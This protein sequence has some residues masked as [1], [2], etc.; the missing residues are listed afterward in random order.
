MRV[1][2]ATT[3]TENYTIN[4]SKTL[5][6]IKQI[7]LVVQLE[8]ISIAVVFQIKCGNRQCETLLHDVE[9]ASS[10]VLCR[11]RTFN[12]PVEKLQELW[13]SIHPL[14]LYDEVNYIFRSISF[15]KLYSF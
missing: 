1:T 5:H 10:L 6:K 4:V 14:E 9:V 11:D 12:Y 15:F 2:R 7:K 13:R 8:L 3:E